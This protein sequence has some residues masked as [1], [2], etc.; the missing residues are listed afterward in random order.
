L[1]RDHEDPSRQEAPESHEDFEKDRQEG[2]EGT[3]DRGDV[4]KTLPDEPRKA[5][6]CP[7]K[8]PEPQEVVMLNAFKPG[9]IHEDRFFP[10][11]RDELKANNWVL[12]TLKKGYMIPFGK[13]IE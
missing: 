10:F 9:L 6:N 7:R 5:E 4:L 1:N 3:N 13:E 12:N 8:E 2:A 11:W